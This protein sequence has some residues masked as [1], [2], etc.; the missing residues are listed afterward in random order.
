M[1]GG[2]QRLPR[3]AGVVRDCERIACSGN[4]FGLFV[5]DHDHDEIAR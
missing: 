2:K 3:F 1:L 4:A 5:S